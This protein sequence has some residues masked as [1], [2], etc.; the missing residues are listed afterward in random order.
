VA[1]LTQ[2]LLRVIYKGVERHMFSM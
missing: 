1:V 2:L